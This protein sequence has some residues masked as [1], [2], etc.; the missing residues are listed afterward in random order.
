MVIKN[1]KIYALVQVD[2]MMICTEICIII[3]GKRER[4]RE[5]NKGS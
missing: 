4:V 1:V 5:R 2:D 3:K